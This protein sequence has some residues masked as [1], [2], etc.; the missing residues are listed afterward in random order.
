VAS[1]SPHKKFGVFLSISQQAV[2]FDTT[3]NSDVGNI[4]QKNQKA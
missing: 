3:K 1:K 4:T 2:S